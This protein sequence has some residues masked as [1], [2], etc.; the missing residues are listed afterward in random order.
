MDSTVGESSYSFKSWLR[1]SKGKKVAVLCGI[2]VFLFLI[3]I[4]IYS[5]KKNTVSKKQITSKEN[6]KSTSLSAP[7][8]EFDN[9]TFS[10]AY[11]QV[12]DTLQLYNLKTE[13]TTAD[14]R[15]LGHAF[16][17]REEKTLTNPFIMMA[18]TTDTE[19]MGILIV[20]RNTGTFSFQSYGLHKP[21]NNT[22]TT[23]STVAQKYLQQI[24]VDDG[25]LTRA[26]TYKQKEYPTVTFV[27][28][29][30]DWEKTALPI[31]NPIGLLNLPEGKPLTTLQLGETEPFTLK[32]PS[33]IA[34]SNN[35]QGTMRPNDFNTVTV[36]VST[37]GT[38]LSIESNLRKISE[39][40]QVSKN[41]LLTPEDALEQFMQTGGDFALTIP[42]G[43]GPVSWEKVYPENLAKAE[44]AIIT[45][46]ILTY[47]ENP[48]SVTQKSL[49]PMY[50][51]RGIAT[52]KSGYTVR[53]L[54][55]LPALK[56]GHSIFTYSRK[57]VAG[58]K[59]KLL[60]QE[61]KKS[62]QLEPYYPTGVTGTV[63]SP[64]RVAGG[65]IEY[66]PLTPTP[67]V[68]YPL[69]SCPAWTNGTTTTI[70][71]AGLGQ[72]VVA[73]NQTF[74]NDTRREYD[75]H[76]AHTFFFRSATFPVSDIED[77]KNKFY[78]GAN[79]L[80]K[81]PGPFEKQLMINVAKRAPDFSATTEEQMY[82]LFRQL[83]FP[84][85]NQPCDASSRSLEPMAPPDVRNCNAS[86]DSPEGKN[87]DLPRLKKLE[88][89]VAK[90]L[91]QAKQAGTL[92][93]LANEPNVFP[94]A[95]MQA[96][97]YI[98][99]NA[100]PYT[101]WDDTQDRFKACY[102]TGT[103]P[104][105]YLYPEKE[106]TVTVQTHAPLTYTDPQTVNNTWVVTADPL[107]MI[108]S[109]TNFRRPYLYYEY[110]K[111][112]V[113]FTESKEGWIISKEKYE[114]FIRETFANVVGL[115]EK[116]TQ[117]MINEIRNVLADTNASSLPYLKV[118]VV[119][120]GEVTTKL[121]LSISPEPKRIYRLHLGISLL[122]KKENSK[123]PTLQKI[124]RDG[125]T[126]VELGVHLV[127]N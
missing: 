107:G 93:S 1:S 72:M 122:E 101:Y 125:F 47:L 85:T 84:L 74:Y 102:I 80:T 78:F 37:E 126:A 38:I 5:P 58:A 66:P 118:S 18:N 76:G 17:L 44:N 88:T 100:T 91:L 123:E 104:V 69:T 3:S 50:T 110:D 68:K 77:V 33:I 73:I 29:H 109:D 52:L 28:F 120:L 48:P 27:E 56:S 60:A 115:H 39:K 61:N 87:M 67:T 15:A 14:I 25:T 36:A 86:P 53:F 40:S 106:T 124:I 13:L 41:D 97:G 42:A 81:P 94:S 43:T 117:T 113:S 112:D 22:D 89:N 64:T 26:V 46:Y 10:A 59:T 6:P 12:P 57:A 63:P 23:P 35:E 82:G 2:S 11:P 8:L 31:L 116:E 9:Y 105:L 45:D 54:Q 21:Q 71:I 7:I 55:T 95:T 19:S 75:R 96:F 51:I 98:F 127:N 34:T 99:G 30:R 16:G 121:P 49:V 111:N 32:N 90:R 114:S 119:P 4:F 103:S 92:Q 70:Q 108:S 65:E 20:N 79:D 83:N 62:L 24:G